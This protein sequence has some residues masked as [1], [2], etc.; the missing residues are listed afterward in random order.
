MEINKDH[1]RSILRQTTC[2]WTKGYLACLLDSVAPSEQEIARELI[3]SCGPNNKINAIKLIRN[4]YGLAL[5]EAKDV[6]D[7]YFR[8]GN[9]VG[10]PN[11]SLQDPPF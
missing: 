7:E 4:N 3:D 11:E 5:K 1:L 10:L 2:G 9:I 6:V 8:T